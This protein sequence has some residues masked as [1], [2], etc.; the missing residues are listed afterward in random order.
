MIID[1]HAH[2]WPDHIAAVV[3]ATRPSGLDSHFDG[4]LTGL[5]TTMD[6][7]GID[8]SMALAVANKASTVMRTNEWIGQI[9]RD[10]LIPAGTVHPGLSPEENVASL[11]DNGI[12]A[13]KLHPLFQD[14]AFADPQVID[15]MHA[16]AA[17]GVTVL[18]HVGSGG[19]AAANERGNPVALRA[20]IDAV[21]TL[22]LVAFHYGGYHQLDTAQEL[23]VG[24]PVLLETSWPPSVATLDPQ[25]VRDLIRRHGVDR[26]VFG[27]DWPMT[28]PAAEIAAI[29]ALGLEPD[30]EAAILGGNLA[31]LLGL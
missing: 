26:V 16:L 4:T 8:L 24:A 5:L 22:R 29:R 7:A 11:R 3:L 9:P 30:E 12:R 20:L 19:D 6:A 28:D 14:V 2:V 25:V 1:A 31:R 27:T 23:I 18:T 17:D 10:R 15:I 21:P 13:V